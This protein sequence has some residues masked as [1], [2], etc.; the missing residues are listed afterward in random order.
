MQ[1]NSV[2]LSVLFLR[3]SLSPSLK[4]TKQKKKAFYYNTIICFELLHQ[5]FYLKNTPYV[6]TVLLSLFNNVFSGRQHNTF[7]VVDFQIEP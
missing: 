4:K 7:K 6:H 2:Y 1:T 3:T 5:N